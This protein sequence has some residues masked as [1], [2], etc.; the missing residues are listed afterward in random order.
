MWAAAGP[1]LQPEV[2]LPD[3]QPRAGV[4]AQ[5]S[6]KPAGGRHQLQQSTSSVFNINKYFFYVTF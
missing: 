3:L 6:G 1:G 4:K 2:V 5:E